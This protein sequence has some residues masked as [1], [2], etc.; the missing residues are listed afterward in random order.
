[1][2]LDTFALQ[3]HLTYLLS[4][5]AEKKHVPICVPAYWLVEA[6]WCTHPGQRQWCRC[7]DG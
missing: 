2:S 6:R 5:K 7:G 1:M 4:L 3:V